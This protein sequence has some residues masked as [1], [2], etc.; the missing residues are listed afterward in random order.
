MSIGFVTPPVGVSL[1]VA[2][3][4]PG[5]V[6]FNQIAKQAVPYVCLFFLAAVIIA[7]APQLSLAFI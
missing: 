6:P 2:T 1:Y 7:F 3:S 4:L 5:K